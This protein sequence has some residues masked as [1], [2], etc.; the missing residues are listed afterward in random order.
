[1]ISKR[2]RILTGIFLALF[3]TVALAQ[4]WGIPRRVF[5]MVV[6]SGGFTSEGTIHAHRLGA[7]SSGIASLEIDNNNPVIIM[8]DDNSASAE[9]NYVI[10]AAAGFF[11]IQGWNEAF[12]TGV[13]YMQIDR[14]GTVGLSTDFRTAALEH[15]GVQ[16]L[17]VADAGV[18]LRAM[19]LSD[20]SRANTITFTDDPTLCVTV[21]A[22]RTYAIELMLSHTSASATPGFKFVIDG[23]ATSGW[24]GVRISN[25]T[26][27]GV[28]GTTFDDATASVA[29]VMTAG[30]VTGTNVHA[31]Y[32]PS[33]AGDVCVQW[34]QIISNATATILREGSWMILTE[35]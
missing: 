20:T 13:T 12:T 8:R 5:A 18:T 26:G 15:N 4:F 9:K 16:V 6:G 10:L 7:E 14:N 35:I 1:M 28:T 23:P 33:F 21:V 27:L 22:G 25:E 30:Q 32:R 17:T 19:K 24:D 3:A 29:I 2:N 31:A 11:E 34:A